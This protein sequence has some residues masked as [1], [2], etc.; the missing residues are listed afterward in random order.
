MGVSAE[1]QRAYEVLDR[2]FHERDHIQPLLASLD[3][4]ERRINVQRVTDLCFGVARWSLYLDAVV[5]E[6]AVKPREKSPAPGAHPTDAVDGDQSM[7]T[8]SNY[9]FG[10]PAEDLSA[11]ETA[12]LS[13]LI[14]RPGRDAARRSAEG[15][16]TRRGVEALE[17]EVLLILRIALYQLIFSLHRPDYA[18]V[19]EATEYAKVLGK[20]N[21][22]R[23]INAVLREYLRRPEVRNDVGVYGDVTE[24]LA[25]RYSHPPFLFRRWMA[26]F[27]HRRTEDILRAD[28]DV[29][30]LDLLVQLRRIS[31]DDMVEKLL[32][33][34]VTTES[35]DLS[36]AGLT[37][38]RGNALGLPEPLRSMFYV[39][40]LSCQAMAWL[41]SRLGGDRLLD[42]AAAPGG[43]SLAL[44]QMHGYST[45]VASDLFLS[46]TVRLRENLR[47][48]GGGITI[49]IQDARK[50]AI[51][52][53]AFDRI[54]LDAPCS[55]TGVLRKNPESR[56]R[57]DAGVFADYHKKQLELLEALLPAL[58]TGGY[59]FY[60]TCSLEPEENEDVVGEFI[61]KHP[62]MSLVKRD[63]RFPRELLA[64]QEQSGIFRIL[65]RDRTDGITG[66][67]M[68][69]S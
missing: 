56:W 30:K 22:S 29:P 63:A 1:F 3:R 4:T 48:F 33:A 44:S 64:H 25:V 53:G 52:R 2:S 66:A 36:P 55:G 41:F 45:H 65:P 14:R 61:A 17:R 23:F 49:V 21:A 32:E 42:A 58:A 11:E 40:D 27:G 13:T 62:E 59:L 54:V 39:E 47:A 7:G 38:M 12:L 10:K 5:A 26:R 19:D 16:R 18:V 15:A 35:T 51:R 6:L 28:Q 60:I 24:N 20:T 31:R 8:A 43:K 68:H 67:I 34:R 69:K 50:P 9:Y 46:R 57:L 37:V